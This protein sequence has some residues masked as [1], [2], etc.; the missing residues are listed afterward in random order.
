MYEWYNLTVKYR[1]D[2]GTLGL[3]TGCLTEIILRFVH[4]LV[5]GTKT[6]QFPFSTLFKLRSIFYMK[7]TF[8]R[9][10]NICVYGSRNTW[11]PYDF[12]GIVH[13]CYHLISY[14]YIMVL[15][16]IHPTQ[17]LWII[18]DMRSVR[19][20]QCAL[21]LFQGAPSLS[22]WRCPESVSRCPH[23]FQAHIV[24]AT[25]RISQLQ[26]LATGICSIRILILAGSTL[27][28]GT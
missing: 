17:K 12:D 24:I 10:I 15:L 13:L 22:Q 27:S 7:I 25:S 18:S 5:N 1:G 28:S 16:Q 8:F 20:S 3:G 4:Q 2:W 9:M 14:V 23:L 11:F 21:K 6:N 26:A 19:V